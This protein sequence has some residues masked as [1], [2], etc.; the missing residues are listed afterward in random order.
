M[1]GTQS[2]GLIRILCAAQFVVALAA[3]AP[4]VKMPFAPESTPAISAGRAVSGLA[5]TAANPSFGERGE[6]NK[7]VTITGSGFTPG[8]AVD[9]ELNGV[10]DAGIVVQSA[11]VVSSTRIDAVISIGPDAELSLHDVAVITADR[12]KG[13]GT[14]MFE[15]TTATS[16]GTLGGNT[17]VYGANDNVSGPRVAGYS[18][19]KD[20]SHAFY[21]PTANGTLGD[22]GL[23]EAQGIDQNGTTIAG[24]SGGYPTVW[25]GG[26][27]AW[28]RSQLP[29]AAGGVGGRAETLV[30]DANG[31][32]A[33]I[34]GSETVKTGKSNAKYPRPRLWRRIGGSWTVQVLPLPSTANDAFSSVS[35]V[36]LSGQAVGM[37]RSAATQAVFWDADGSAVLLPGPAG[38]GASGGINAAGTLIAG[39]VVATNSY[40]VYWTAVINTD[41]SRTWSGPFTLPGN[42]ERASGI[43]ANDR[44]VGQRCLTDGIRY[45]SAIWSPPYDSNSITMLHGLGV[46]TDAGAAW[47]MSPNGTTIGGTAPV[48][49]SSTRVGVIWSGG[50]F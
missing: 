20:G 36:N 3:C 6:T 24:I 35:G 38:T 40:A 11:V 43:D 2:G 7:P 17:V 19:L 33:I 29:L 32:A 27:G 37:V 8:A 14:E 5:V 18:S 15:V 46:K 30:S 39:Q 41:G 13:I 50:A 26:E 34:G 12:K 28:A 48:N 9:F 25:E 22:L 44:I 23:G 45:L 42:C 47:A 4:D 31:D 49:G 21:W 16:I 1:R 10:A